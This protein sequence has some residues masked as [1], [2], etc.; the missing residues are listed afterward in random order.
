MNEENQIIKLEQTNGINTNGGLKS[1]FWLFIWEV[2]KIVI[3]SLAII[4]PVRYYLAQPFFV[5]GASMEHTFEDGDY[6]II[7]E[8]TYRLNSPQR[9]DVIVFR[10]PG[11]SSQFFIKR[12]IGLPN[13][14]LELKSSQVVIRNI[15]NPEGFILDEKAYLPEKH[16]LGPDMRIKLD[17]NEYFVMGDNRGQSSDS[18][19]WGPLTKSLFVGKAWMGSCPFNRVS[20]FPPLPYFS[21]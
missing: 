13:E 17:D 8:I 12:I 14:T 7:N 11:D 5:K 1:E 15:K 4:V 10:F 19:H 6:L 21:D 16:L 3:I 2:A 18:R 9:G 20:H